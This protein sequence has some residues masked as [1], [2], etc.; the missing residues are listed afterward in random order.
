MK[1]TIIDG[2]FA[3]TI[4]I[5]LMFNVS[6]ATM[7]ESYVKSD[8]HVIQRGTIEVIK[9]PGEKT[10]TTIVRSDSAKTTDNTEN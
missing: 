3:L 2:L 4:T 1:R 6:C 10:I 5:L 8:I 9:K 7:S